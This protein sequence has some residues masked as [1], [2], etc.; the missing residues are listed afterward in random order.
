[1]KCASFFF[2]PRA[3]CGIRF[4]VRGKASR[5]FGPLDPRWQPLQLACAPCNAEVSVMVRDL[6]REFGRQ[7]AAMALGVPGMNVRVW[8]E[9][10]GMSYAAKRAVW[11][12]WVLLLHPGRVRSAWDVV[13][14]GRFADNPSVRRR[15]RKLSRELT[16]QEPKG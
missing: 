6:V 16:T 11:F 1:M 15:V 9:G 8:M 10:K 14:W 4:C 13:T 12:A 2:S 7:G 3:T 5:Q